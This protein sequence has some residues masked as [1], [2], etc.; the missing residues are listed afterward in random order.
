MLDETI[1]TGGAFN[2]LVVRIKRKRTSA[3]VVIH[4]W[5]VGSVSWV[6]LQVKWSASQ[7]VSHHCTVVDG[8]A[9]AVGRREKIW[10]VETQICGT[11]N[12]AAV[13][14]ANYYLLAV[15]VSC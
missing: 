15:A 11:V 3:A 5:S 7:T 14:A 12:N 8:S 1:Q 2:S 6:L 10:G 4:S 13:V 9:P